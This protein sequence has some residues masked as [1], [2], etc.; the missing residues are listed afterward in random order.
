MTHYGMLIDAGTCCGCNACTFACKYQNATP[1]GMYWTK[2]IQGEEGTYP[3]VRQ[4]VMPL[5]CQHCANAPCVRA[6]PT[7]ASH[8]DENGNEQVHYDKCIGCRRCMGA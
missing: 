1:K 6:C 3:D 7:G 5:G 4:T 2:V 8:Y